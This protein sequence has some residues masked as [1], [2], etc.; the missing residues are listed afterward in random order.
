MFGQTNILHRASN[1]HKS[2]ET[3]H[4]FL[5]W[6]Y[7]LLFLERLSNSPTITWEVTADLHLEFWCLLRHK[8]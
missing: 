3:K 2:F 1:R 6:A 4:S 7:Q 8:P 5:R